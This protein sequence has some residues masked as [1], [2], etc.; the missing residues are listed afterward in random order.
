MDTEKPETTQPVNVSGIYRLVV[1]A[2]S[3]ELAAKRSRSRRVLPRSKQHEVIAPV[4]ISEVEEVQTCGVSAKTRKQASWACGVY[5][6][7]W[8]NE[9]KELPSPAYRLEDCK[10]YLLPCQ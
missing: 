9:W 1:A 10:R 6:A 7:A 2:V 3:Q 8:A 5:R 4:S